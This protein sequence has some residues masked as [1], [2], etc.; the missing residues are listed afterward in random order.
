MEKEKFNLEIDMSEYVHCDKEIVTSE[1]Q[2]ISELMPSGDSEDKHCE[3]PI[4]TVSTSWKAIAGLKTVKNFLY[5]H[6]IQELSLQKLSK[7]E[8]AIYEIVD[9]KAKITDFFK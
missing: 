8:N 5:A 3:E 6:K 2:K 1:I 7:I 4:D 9:M